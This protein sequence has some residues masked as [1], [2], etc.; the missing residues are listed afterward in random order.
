MALMSPAASDTVGR[1]LHAA[2]GKWNLE[3]YL[4]H[5]CYVLAAVAIVYNALGRLADDSTVR[6]KIQHYVRLPVTI[7]IPLLLAA[8]WLSNGGSTYHADFLHMPTDP[9]LSAYWI[10]L[11][12]MLIYLLGYGARALLVL[13]KD[14]RSQP[15]AD[16]YLMASAFGVL[17]FTV[18]IFTA[19]FP[20]LVA[21]EGGRVVWFF[22]CTCGAGFA[23]A[24]AQSWRRRV[25]WFRDMETC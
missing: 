1:L 21:M 17:A 13:R 15:I 12:G 7:C 23:L 5:D 2:T 18:R 10:V 4:G 19:A 22:S 24:S 20:D 3:D 9:W 11:G 8:L 6:F 14:P 25:R 16:I